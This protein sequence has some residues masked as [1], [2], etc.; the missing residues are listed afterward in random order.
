MA[1]TGMGLAAVALVMLV[2]CK[3]EAPTGSSL[4]SFDVA[5]EAPAAAADG[6]AAPKPDAIKVALP[7]IA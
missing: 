5:E 1:R 2:G 7:Q 3:K 4:R 6:A